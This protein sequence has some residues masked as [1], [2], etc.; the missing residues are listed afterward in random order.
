MKD[1]SEV[2]KLHILKTDRT[3]G[4]EGSVA[5]LPVII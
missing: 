1:S 5:Q 4:D 3:T 2:V